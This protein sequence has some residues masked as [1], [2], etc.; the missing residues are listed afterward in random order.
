VP[1]VSRSRRLNSDTFDDDDDDDDDDG[2][3]WWW[4]FTATPVPAVT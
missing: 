4:W 3:W 1:Y 2:W